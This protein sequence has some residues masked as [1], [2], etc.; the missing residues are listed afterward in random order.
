M[1][2]T[3]GLLVAVSVFLVVGCSGGNEESEP[4]PQLE[5]AAPDQTEAPAA[6]LDA[7]GQLEQL[8]DS[9]ASQTE[10]DLAELSAFVGPLPDATH[11]E[12]DAS[13]YPSFTGP[14]NRLRRDSDLS[15]EQRAAVDEAITSLYTPE[16][17]SGAFDAGGRILGIGGDGE[18]GGDLPTEC[19]TDTPGADAEVSPELQRWRDLAATEMAQLETELPGDLDVVISIADPEIWDPEESGAGT[20]YRD[21]MVGDDLTDVLAD[22][23]GRHNCYI[24][25]GR[26]AVT[27]S[28]ATGIMAH[29]LF[30]CWHWTHFGASDDRYGNPPLWVV[31][32]LAG[33]FGERAAGGTEYGPNWWGRYFGRGSGATAEGPYSLFDSSYDAIGFW[34]TVDDDIDL[35]TA[36]PGVVD[37]AAG[38]SGGAWSHIDSLMGE[39]LPTVASAPTQRSELGAIWTISGP[40]MPSGGRLIPAVTVGVDEPLTL[41]VAAG[42][43]LVR[44]IRFEV[45]A[46]RHVIET[47]I[48]GEVVLDWG[49][50][51]FDDLH[52][53]N[54]SVLRCLGGECVCPE[55][56][57]AD[58]PLPLD[59]SS[60]PTLALTG[61]AGGVSTGISMLLTPLEDWCD[62]R[63]GFE[64][65][66][67]DLL[68]T[69]RADNGALTRMFAAVYAGDGSAGSALEVAGVDGDVYLTLNSGGDGTL[70]YEETNIYFGSGAPISNVT[71][72]GVGQ[73]GWTVSDG[74]LTINSSEFLMTVSSPVLGDQVLSLT[75]EDTGGGG[76]TFTLRFG[77]EADH[78]TLFD[79]QGTRDEGFANYFPVSWFRQ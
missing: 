65:G 45:T 22:C 74:L 69:W 40:G 38:G 43:Q 5:S 7:V 54:R 32:G 31:E 47:A 50:G 13:L 59:A 33:W 63:G 27:G 16:R 2:L 15:D 70:A 44:E 79:P 20:L 4:A 53:D 8:K 66:D 49:D 64:F 21:P 76:G 42:E 62:E 24:M 14:L 67:S 26:T 3:S 72:N 37:Q 75:D 58:T 52:A 34:S 30:H 73:I 61:A 12:Y 57:S 28:L 55:G 39:S 18:V 56:G 68:G 19:P 10:I 9:G 1:R 78:L 36:I 48:A 17:L 29:E 77:I 25:I 46:D 6:P 51:T 71:L 35:V 11:I 23:F 60:V 41:D